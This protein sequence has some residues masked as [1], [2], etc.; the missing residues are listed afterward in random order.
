MAY[1]L[2]SEH[3]ELLENLALL[4]EAGLLDSPLSF[5]LQVKEGSLVKNRN[6]F[7]ENE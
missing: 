4:K 2:D 7:G 6:H 5:Y 1:G 3:P